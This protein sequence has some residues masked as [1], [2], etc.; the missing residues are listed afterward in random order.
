M[1]IYYLDA[2]SITKLYLRDERGTEFMDKLVRERVPGERLVTSEISI[3]EVKA[4]ISRRVR[5]IANRRAL[6]R[7]YD[8]D[9]REI[10]ETSPVSETIIISA[11]KIAEERRLRSGDAIHLATALAVAAV[12]PGS[13]RMFMVSSDTELLTASHETL[14]GALDPQ[15]DDAPDDAQH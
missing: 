5:N 12:A 7:A 2:S 11:S 1:P 14:L 8:N 6:I 15:T 9:W 13:P 10:F 3:V 4:A